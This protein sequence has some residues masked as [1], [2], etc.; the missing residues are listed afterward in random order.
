MIFATLQTP[1]SPLKKTFK[2]FTDTF[3]LPSVLPNDIEALKTLLVTQQNAHA[4]A[5]Q[6]LHQE[7]QAIRQEAHDYVIRMLEQAALARQRMFGASSEQ[8]SAQSRLFDEAEALA[9][10]STEAQDI[11]PIAPEVPAADAKAPGVKPARGKRAP[12]AA[13]L[14]RVDVIHDVAEADR[15]C[16]CGTPMV[17]IGQDISEQLD[18]VPMQVRV[19]RH[20]R[21]RYG[22]PSSQHAPVTAALPA[23]PLPKSNASADFLAMLLAVKFVDGLP[24]ARF[25]KVLDRHD[26]T[27]PRQTLARW[28]I[29]CAGLLQ[30][31]H[32]LMRDILLDGGLIYMDETVVQVLKEKDKAPTSN[33]Y[34]WV[35]T[36][37]PPDKP[38][39][40]YDYDPS[41][42]ASVPTALLEGFK[43]YLMTDGY[44]GYN[45]VAR[46]EGIERL[47]C[48]AHVRR[49]FVEATRVQPK[50]KRGRADE[51]VC[52]IGKLYRLEREYKDAKV[53]DRYLA[54]QS[55]SVPVLAELHAWML[56]NT[57][58]VT[59]K[60]ALGTALA[61]MANLWPQLTRYTERGDLPIDNNRC[62]NAI[63]PFV[64]G[65]NNANCSLMRTR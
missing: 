64:I 40:L 32:N 8:M 50:G 2:A 38:V 43:G 39:V 45:A 16:A 41:R 33:S 56:K 19:L 9:Q 25:E 13:G 55:T 37:G 52:L 31:L 11:A 5:L 61:Y 4:A 54:R 6:T 65:R 17:E 47:A 36:G 23:Q 59:P 53:E 60:S 35:Q 34:M 22:C 15:T 58:L 30:P 28:V 7:A 10:T 29:G 51:A 63:R 21:K 49:R 14:P 46:I 12:L 26:A 44:D 57:P 3:T 62:E 42:S 48:W 1:F 18:I 20:I 24:L 27:V